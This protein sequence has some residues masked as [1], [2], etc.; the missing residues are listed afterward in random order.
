MIR[1]GR[2]YNWLLA[3]SLLLLY[4]TGCSSWQPGKKE[5][6]PYTRTELKE[7]LREAA[8]LKYKDLT[9]SSAVPL[10]DVPMEPKDEIYNRAKA[11]VSTDSGISSFD[12]G[13]DHL[14]K[15]VLE[16]NLGLKVDAYDPATAEERFKA[17]QGK[18]EAVLQATVSV[19]EEND[20]SLDSAKTYL[21]QPSVVIPTRLG[22]ELTL[23]FPYTKYDSDKISSYDMLG[24]PIREGT[25]YTTGVELKLRQPLLRGAGLKVNYANIHTADLLARQAESRTKL[26]AIRLLAL[27]E[28]TYWRYYSAYENLKIQVKKYELAKEQL[29]MSKR[30]VEEGVRT[31]VEVTRSEAG[32]AREFESIIRAETQRRR[33]ERELK[34]VMNLPDLP[35]ES[36]T[37]IYPVVKPQPAGLVFD[38]PKVIDLGY[39]HRMDLFENE[40]QQ[41]IDKISVD[42]SH[43]RTLPLLSWDFTY[44]FSGSKPE[45]NDALD[46]ILEREYNKVTFGL[47]MQF[48]LEGNRGAKARWRESMLK[49]KKTLAQRANLELAIRQE[50][51][52]AVDALEQNWQRIIAS[53]LAMKL[54]RDNYEAELTQFRHGLRTS[55][56]VLIALTDLST[57]ALGHVQALADYQSS[58][59]DVAFATGTVLGKSG[60]IWSPMMLED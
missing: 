20:G 19:S 12:L 32:V 52:N 3:A 42:L 5:W 58:L 39:A 41:A 40:L 21:P 49:Q 47:T 17:E 26:S 37:V 1:N 55:T 51:L 59:V 60:V 16:N 15:G 54:S 25:T 22:G 48:P 7:K 13:L 53:R 50:V 23:G 2:I 27:S 29:R 30:M 24:N 4:A 14:R 6:S 36:T 34:K 10:K 57:S 31:K 56:D 33:E 44:S 18:F 28:Q 46:K 43:N 38:R 8:P 9:R 35:V 11:V 45:F